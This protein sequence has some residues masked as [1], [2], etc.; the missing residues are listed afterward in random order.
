MTY[1]VD[2]KP[3][4]VV[5]HHCLLCGGIPVQPGMYIPNEPWLFGPKPVQDGKL[6]GLLYALCQACVDS[7]T[8]E[9]VTVA[10]EAKLFRKREP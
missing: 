8:I 5:Y 2:G 7:G 10:V 4:T 3:F 9:E 6:R 1:L